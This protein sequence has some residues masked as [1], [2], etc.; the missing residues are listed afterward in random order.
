MS[1]DLL[2][3]VQVYTVQ[4]SKCTCSLYYDGSIDYF[5][6]QHLPYAILALLFLVL[7]VII[8]VATL[9]LSM[10]ILPEIAQLSS[11]A[12][13]HTTYFCRLIPRML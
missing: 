7:F 6:K 8:P 2:M 12:M 10:S 9:L 4:S 13:V 1:F 5:G 11:L 3:P